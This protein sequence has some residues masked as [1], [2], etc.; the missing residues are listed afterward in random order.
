MYTQIWIDPYLHF[1][2]VKVIINHFL[3]VWLLCLNHLSHHN[4]VTNAHGPLTPAN[5]MQVSIMQF[6]NCTLNALVAGTVRRLSRHGAVN[7]T[8]AS[9]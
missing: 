7:L 3:I 2:E 8:Y 9:R 5:S 1:I 4:G 6:D